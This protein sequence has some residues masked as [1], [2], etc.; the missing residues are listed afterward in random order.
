M[1]L[2]NNGHKLG[3]GGNGKAATMTMAP[4]NFHMVKMDISWLDY[5]VN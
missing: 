4:W 2:D 1:I 3:G 5:V